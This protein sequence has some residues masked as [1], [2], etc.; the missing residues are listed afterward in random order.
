MQQKKFDIARNESTS[1]KELLSTLRLDAVDSLGQQVYRLLHRLIGQLRLLPNQFLSEKDVSEGLGISRT[2]VR[3]AFIRLAEDGKVRIIPKSGTYVAPIDVNR[4]AEGLFIWCGL[5]SSCVS[6]IAENI[7]VVGI[8][9]LRDYVT[10]QRHCLSTGDDKGFYSA[11]EKFHDA[12]FALSDFPGV[13][14][15]VHNA[16][17]EIHR[18]L[19]VN[20]RNEFDMTDAVVNEQWQ[21]VNAVAERQKAPA[22]KSMENHLVRVKRTID[23]ILMEK[24]GSQFLQRIN[25]KKP[26][27]RQSKQ[28]GIA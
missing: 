10:V 18:L 13:K 21:I 26:G 11:N 28:E 22:R 17:F 27:K 7:S 1:I 24:N 4:V 2:P 25:R 8:S 5:E 6:R 16:K 12:I 23:D 20:N 15:M 14:E 19:G 3:E 9:R